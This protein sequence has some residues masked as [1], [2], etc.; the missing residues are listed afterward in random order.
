[1]TCTSCLSSTWSDTHPHGSLDLGRIDLIV[2]WLRMNTSPYVD[3]DSYLVPITVTDL[4]VFRSFTDSLE[5]GRLASVRPPDD[6]DPETAEFLLE[7]FE[8][9]CVFCRHSE[10]GLCKEK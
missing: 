5:N 3:L 7:V 10:D 8:I 9:I 1:M 6:K 4:R 2:A